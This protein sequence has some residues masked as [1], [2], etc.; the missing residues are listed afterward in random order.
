[1]VFFGVP[2]LQ[3]RFDK[4]FRKEYLKHIVVMLLITAAVL[5]IRKFTGE[6]RVLSAA[7]DP[8]GVV[9]KIFI[10]L[11]YGPIVNI[12]LFVRAPF[13]AIDEWIPFPYYEWY[14]F[15]LLYAAISLAVFYFIFSKLKNE[16]SLFC[17]GGGRIHYN[18]DTYSYFKKIASISL[19]A[20]ILISISYASSFTHFPPDAVAGRKTSVHLAAT[21][22][23]SILFAC[24]TCSLIYV[25]GV[26]KLR[27]LGTFLL[28]LYLTLLV[29]YRSII[30]VEFVRCQDYQD[31]FWTSIVDLCPDMSDGTIIIV[32][33]KTNAS[34]TK[35]VWAHGWSDHQMLNHL[36]AFPAEWKRPPSVHVHFGDL[37][38]AFILEK[39]KV[40]LKSAFGR[41]AELKTEV[42]D[43]NLIIIKYDNATGF[44]RI[45]TS[46]AVGNRT[47]STKRKPDYVF[48]FKK[49]SLYHVLIE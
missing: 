14:H 2:L 37:S 49:Q 29:L 13:A 24:I 30:Q 43:S 25:L 1:M 3:G 23:G 21:F 35:Y 16:N 44:Q 26:F 48:D 36:F 19:P 6:S 40:N 31:R 46:I 27:K 34:G 41:E 12:Y 8:F 11:L 15:F 18:D 47:I 4:E 22:G 33:L 5:M 7:G 32:N 17:I 39:D 9:Y 28:S 38:K 20:A 45:D 10:A 42:P